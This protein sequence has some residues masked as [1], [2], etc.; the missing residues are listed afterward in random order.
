MT[1]HS[2]EDVPIDLIVDG[3][4]CGLATTFEAPLPASVGIQ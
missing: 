1:I 3:K 4:Y 2:K